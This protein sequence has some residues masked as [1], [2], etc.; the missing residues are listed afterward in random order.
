M[1]R[2]SKIVVLAA[3]LGVVAEAPVRAHAED[4]PA[5]IRIAYPGVGIG[6]R[7]SVGGNSAAVMHLRGILEDEF[8]Q[9]GIKVTWTFLRGAGPAVNELYANNLADFSLLGDLPSL[10]GKSGGLKTRMLAATGIRGN[11]YFVV[12][13]D[14]P[15]QT[16]KDMR[17]K[18][19]ALFKGTNNQLAAN[20]VLEANGMSEK[21]VRFINMD[22]ASYRAALVTG[23]IDGAFGGS[24]LIGLRDQGAIRIVYRTAGDPRF[25]RHASFIGAEAFIQKYP[26]ITQRVVTSLVKAAK[27]ISDQDANPTIAFQL[28]TKSGVRFADYREDWQGQSLKVFSSPLID[29]YLISQY[30]TQVK[31]AKKFGLIKNDVSIDNWVEPRFLA[32]ALKDLKLENFWQPV[33]EDGVVPKPTASVA[34]PSHVTASR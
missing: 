22:N 11:L 12:P 5:V 25:L 14:S 3:L 17:G 20:K 32:Q 13:S 30:K 27:W 7:P 24:D 23:D 26:Q 19:I 33:G 15:I 16:L 2:L 34:D 8:K 21:D 18:R 6:N 1:R 28:W 10:I 29:P 4:K 31:Q 9:D